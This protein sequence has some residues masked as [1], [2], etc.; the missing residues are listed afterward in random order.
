MKAG[1]IRRLEW[2]E[3][4]LLLLGLVAAVLLSA[5]GEWRAAGVPVLLFF[6]Y[7]WLLKRYLPGSRGRLL[8]AYGAVWAEYAGFSTMVDL[9]GIP[10]R[11]EAL[12]AVDRW[13]FGRMPAEA[14]R[15]AFA[16]WF[17]EWLSLAYLGYQIYLHWFL[18]E[19]WGRDKA[20]RQA[21]CRWLFPG[22]AAGM[23]LYLL[24][25]AAPPVSAFPELFGGPPT[26]G[27][28]TRCNADLNAALA[29]RYD[30]FP[31]LHVLITLLLLS[32]DW[33]FR[34]LRFWS[35]LPGS[36]LMLLATLALGLHY[37]ADLLA[38]SILFLFLTFLHARIAT[39]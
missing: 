21:M 16:P 27:A 3:A 34:R 2:Y 37:A 33:R 25:P 20:R 36:V 32:W 17:Y 1:F 19:A 38:A 4:M 13:C 6:G 31:S 14:L 9:A 39:R 26:G 10:L 18:L 24:W 29:A 22:F 35:M 5:A 11:H 15:G 12:R 8:A 7:G 30:A 28:I 23:G